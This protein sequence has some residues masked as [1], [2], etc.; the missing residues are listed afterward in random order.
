[1]L[2]SPFPAQP[3]SAPRTPLWGER[4]RKRP[5]K[6]NTGKQGEQIRQ[7]KSILVI[8]EGAEGKDNTTEKQL[9]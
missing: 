4:G 3:R 7:R 1:M 8:T 2:M 6:V 5:H 9:A